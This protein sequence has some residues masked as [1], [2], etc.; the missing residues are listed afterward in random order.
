MV[1]FQEKKLDFFP[2]IV[3]SGEIAIDFVQNYIISQ[4]CLFPRKFSFAKK[5][6]EMKKLEKLLK[7]MYQKKNAFNL[8]KSIFIEVGGRKI[9][10]LLP[11]VLCI[12]SQ[13]NTMNSDTSNRFN[14]EL[15]IIY[16]TELS[17]PVKP[18]LF[19]RSARV[20]DVRFPKLKPSIAKHWEAKIIIF[21]KIKLHT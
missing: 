5:I 18:R 2:K 11:A 7:S 17:F 6:F 15:K 10:R 21:V 20:Y 4:K 12:S 16:R 9:C 1:F 3:K 14:A 19:V 13:L 8:L